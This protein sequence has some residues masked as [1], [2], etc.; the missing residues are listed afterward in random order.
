MAHPV[1]W[2]MNPSEYEWFYDVGA[3]AI[4]VT[5]TMVVHT[6]FHLGHMHEVAEPDIPLAPVVIPEAPLTPPLAPWDLPLSPLL[7]CEME[8][9]SPRPI[10]Q[11]S[12]PASS[13]YHRAKFHSH[14]YDGS[15]LSS[16][17]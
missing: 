5:T 6:N 16:L 15:C 12:A 2:I 4:M 17:P 13:P 1:E 10:G 3:N 14:S 9:M 11:D 7:D 8:P